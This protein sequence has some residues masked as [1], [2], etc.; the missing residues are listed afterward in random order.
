MFK[1]G[2]NLVIVPSEDELFRIMTTVV[3]LSKGS[4]VS[5]LASHYLSLKVAYTLGR[6]GRNFYMIKAG[7]NVIRATVIFT[8][9]LAR[10]DVGMGVIDNL[11]V[12]LRSS[13]HPKWT[14]RELSFITALI[15]WASL[16]SGK[17]SVWVVTSNEGGLFL[18]RMGG[19]LDQVIYAL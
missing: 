18:K 4:V 2:L 6:E 5:L 1:L 13:A 15:R 17:P 11:V 9:Y 19:L 16:E 12:H 10:R 7:E 14:H 8:G 3:R